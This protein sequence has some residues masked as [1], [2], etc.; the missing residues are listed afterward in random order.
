[1]GPTGWLAYS[2]T[3]T[4]TVTP[5]VTDVAGNALEAPVVWSFTTGPVCSPYT[6]PATGME[7]VWVEGGTFQM[8]DT[9]GD[10]AAYGRCGYEQPVH[11]VTLTRGYY[12]GKT[13][14]T[15][16]QWA[17]VMGSNPSY[18]QPSNGYPS[19]PT[20]PVEQVSWNDIQ[21]FVTTLNAST[22]KSYRLPTEAEWEYA[23]ASGS[24]QARA[25]K[26]K[27]AGTSD[28]AALGDYAWYSDNAGSQTHPV[29][30]KL[31]NGLGL[32]DMSGNVWEWVQDSWSYYSASPVT[33]PLVQG[34]SYRVLR[35][36][37]WLYYADYER[38]AYRDYNNPDF[39]YF[40][41]GFGLALSP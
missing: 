28:T 22:G 24:A 41:I 32:Y 29:G 12:L 10:C 7:F 18:F 2:T 6:D 37:S 33:D 3:Y 16:A 19:C 17:A 26:Q 8:G 30:G 39:R 27:Y 9:F 21:A 38:V 23:A 34:G 5:G 35:G 14:V 31:A 11:E 36:G 25:A 4:A 20:C 13:E 15:Q 1:M 40:S